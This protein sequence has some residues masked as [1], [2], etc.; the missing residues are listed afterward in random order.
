MK[1][2]VLFDA[3][4]WQIVGIAY[5][6]MEVKVRLIFLNEFSPAH[7]FQDIIMNSKES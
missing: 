4:S 5:Q 7:N 2:S 1:K 3:M 6:V